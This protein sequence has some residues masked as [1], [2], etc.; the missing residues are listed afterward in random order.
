MILKTLASM[1]KQFC[2]LLIMM[3]VMAMVLLFF[4]SFVYSALY[5]L[6]FI[7]PSE[8][9]GLPYGWIPLIFYVMVWFTLTY[10]RVSIKE[11]K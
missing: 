3:F 1:A 10:W 9:M 5:L 4:G 6:E 8:G 2:E 11:N 7:F